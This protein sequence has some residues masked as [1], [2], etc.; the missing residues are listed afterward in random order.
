MAGKKALIIVAVLLIA[1]LPLKAEFLLVRSYAEALPQFS[2]MTKD[3]IMSYD[4]PSDPGITKATFSLAFNALLAGAFDRELYSVYIKKD[5]AASPAEAI[6]RIY[7]ADDSGNT[8]SAKEDWGIHYLGLGVRKYF[9]ENLFAPDE[10]IFY[11]GADFGMWF[12]A[13]T[14]ADLTVSYGSTANGKI[15][16]QGNFWGGSLETGADYWFG[17]AFGVTLKAGYRLCSG[18]TVNT[19][20]QGDLKPAGISDIYETDINY[21]GLYL[22]FGVMMVFQEYWSK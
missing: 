16:A 10:L 4:I 3:R 2:F 13:S 7:D 5:H 11:A 21:S 9:G 18:K 6:T 14:E 1:A 17:N 8:Y 19:V 12:T 22:Q 20:Y 15:R